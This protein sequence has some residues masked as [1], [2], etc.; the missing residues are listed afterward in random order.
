[1]PRERLAAPR[2][3][4]P[5]WFNS[6]W[7]QPYLGPILNECIICFW[8]NAQRAPEINRVCFPRCSQENILHSV[9]R[10]RCSTG[11]GRHVIFVSCLLPPVSLCLCL[12]FCLSP[13][14]RRPSPDSRLTF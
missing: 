1:M 7:S 14:S 8:R 5:P 12:C 4:R 9:A 6:T 13:L 10:F 2:T 11:I 3:S